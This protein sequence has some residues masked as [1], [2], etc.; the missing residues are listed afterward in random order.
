MRPSVQP[1][2]TRARKIGALLALTIPLAG[3]APGSHS[4][5]AIP[6]FNE[7]RASFATS[8]SQLLDRNGVVLATQRADRS[9]RRLD[10]IALSDISAVVATTLVAAEDKRFYEHA[11][12][13]W[14][15]FASA[16]W[17][18]LWRTF[19]GRGPR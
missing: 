10:W 19:D 1:V 13:D 17:D 14:S 16:A 9:I 4:A 7:V 15:G 11:G 8:E 3:Y 18:S 5:A 6:A 12:V 2:A